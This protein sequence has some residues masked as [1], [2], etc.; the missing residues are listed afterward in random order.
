M[1][2][3]IVSTKENPLL[4]R[5]EVGFRIEQ[6]SP[7][8]TPL[9]LDVSRDTKSHDCMCMSLNG[10]HFLYYGAVLYMHLAYPRQSPRWACYRCAD[11]GVRSPTDNVPKRVRMVTGEPLRKLHPVKG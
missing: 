5:K 4:K 1:E 7:A 8:K 10:C 3:K 11:D 9:R 2:V 6:S